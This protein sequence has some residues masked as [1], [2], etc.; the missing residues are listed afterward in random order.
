MVTVDRMPNEQAAP[1]RA[2][3]VPHNPRAANLPMTHPHYHDKQLAGLRWEYGD[4][5]PDQLQT[6]YQDYGRK[7]NINVSPE[8]EWSRIEENRSRKLN[9]N[10]LRGNDKRRTK[11]TARKRQSVKSNKEWYGDELFTKLT[12]KWAK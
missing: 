3:P 4:E 7:H 8:G 5:S 9:E 6:A 2:D 11:T 12:K 10:L 1:T